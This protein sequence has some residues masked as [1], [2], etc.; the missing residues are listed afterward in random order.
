[1]TLK[2]LKSILKDLPD[3]YEVLVDLDYELDYGSIVDELIIK[4]YNTDADFKALYLVA[5]H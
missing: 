2:Q 3:D 5:E 4:A 1:M